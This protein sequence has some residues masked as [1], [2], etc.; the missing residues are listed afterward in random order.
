MSNAKK[1]VILPLIL[2]LSLP[3]LEIQSYCKEEE[4]T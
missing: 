3:K 1:P 2:L 4:D